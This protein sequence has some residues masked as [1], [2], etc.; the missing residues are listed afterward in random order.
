MK[1]KIST[2]RIDKLGRITIPADIRKT[3]S[4][5]DFEELEIIS[6]K[7]KIIIRKPGHPDIFGNEYDEECCF[8]YQGNKISKKSILDLSRMAGIIE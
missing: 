2:R 6:D 8:E 3:L 7:N 4:I 1:S 5:N